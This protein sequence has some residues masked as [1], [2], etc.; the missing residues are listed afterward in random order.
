MPGGIEWLARLSQLAVEC[1]E[2]WELELGPPFAGSNASL[3]MPAGDAVLKINF[4]DDESEHEPYALRLWNGDGAVRLLRHD[5]ER[6][7]LLIERCEPGTTLLELDDDEAGD[8]VP[9]LLPRLWKSPSQ[10]FRLLATVAERWIKELPAQ[11]E[12]FGRPFERAILD[13]AVDALREL[14]PTQGPL[15]VA[16][17]DLHAGN[18]LAS[19]REPWLVIDPKPL[20]AEREFTLVAMIRDRTDEV[21]AGPQPLRRL[22]RRLDR[23]TSDLELD[24]ERVRGWTVAH[25]VAWGFEPDG[26]HAAHAEMA[27][28]L[29]KA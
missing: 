24:R 13:A 17:E 6:R 7:A 2:Q 28:L 10:E 21:L 12:S 9:G 14:G 16:N 18:V 11:W 26:F 3:V 27:R 22:R 8:V 25:T 15:V 4:P 19:Q 5:P 29:L 23:L 1:A 20:A